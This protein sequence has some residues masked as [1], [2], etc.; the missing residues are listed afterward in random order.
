NNGNLLTRGAFLSNVATNASGSLPGG[1]SYLASL[2]Q[3]PDVVI[4][5][6]PGDSRA[7]VLQRPRIQTSHNEPAP[8]FVC[9]KGP[10]PS[11]SY[12]GGGAYGGYASI[13]QVPIG[14]TLEVTPLINPD[15]LV[16]MDISADIQS[17]NGTVTI[18]NVGDVPITSQKSA[19]A[20]ISVHDR[21]TIM[22]GGL[23]ETTKSKSMSG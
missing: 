3:D 18:A 5:A 17:E 22:L 13:Q 7:R 19:S 2:G 9:Q 1:F 10:P 14:V 12:Y 4:T 23:I 8:P 15:G 20:K 21:D 6:V 11:S 16:V